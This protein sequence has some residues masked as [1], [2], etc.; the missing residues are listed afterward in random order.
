MH[1][2]DCQ[3]RQAG[4]LGRGPGEASRPAPGRAGWRLGEASYHRR[5]AR[6]RVSLLPLHQPTS[7]T[8][9]RFLSFSLA[10]DDQHFALSS[11][12]IVLKHTPPTPSPRSARA[13]LARL[14]PLSQP[15][16]S[17]LKQLVPAHVT[18]L[19]FLSSFEYLELGQLRE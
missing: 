18:R 9:P 12:A 1:D 6:S 13:P 14:A 5:A 17:Q 7:S 2:G 10:F 3:G 11:V 16:S 19:V 8:H 15:Q 4:A